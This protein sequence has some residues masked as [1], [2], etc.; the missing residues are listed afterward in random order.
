MGA[1]ASFELSQLNVIPG[2][3]T[4]TRLRVRNTGSVVDQ[5][6][7]EPIGEAAEWITVAPAELSLF[8]AAEETVVVSVDAPREPT[9]R[10]GSTP[11]A[12]RVLSR[13][14]PTGSVAEEGM[15]DV[16]AFDERRVELLPTLSSSSRQGTHELAVDNH[17]NAPIRPAF[18]ALDP[19]DQLRFEID[20]SVLSVEPGTAGFATVKVRPKDR[21]W[22]G[23]PK[24]LP[25]QI[26]AAEDG[27]DPVT[28]EGALL[29]QPRLPRWFW[30][31]VLAALLLLLLLFILWKTLLEPS[32]ESTARD[33]AEELVQEEVA[34]IDERLDAAGIPEAPGPGEEPGG[35]E[36]GGGEDTTPPTVAEVTTTTAADSGPT[37][38]SIVTATT[39]AG[40]SADL[41]PLGQPIDFRL[42]AVVAPTATGLNSFTVPAGQVLSITDIVLQNPTGATGDLRIKRSGVTLFETQLA[43][44]R[45]L[46][47]HFVSPYQFAEGAT[48]D[49]EVICTVPGPGTGECGAS[50]S[51]AG[52]QRE[53]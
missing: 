41:S 7:F 36:P 34:A 11:F 50:A 47:F 24:R 28:A 9:T 6:T 19:E 1:S 22:R 45:D 32:I 31:A 3:H 39:V 30:K 23:Q 14:D 4:E 12:I 29:Q 5:F 13:E 37:T 16:A 8:P 46:D 20:P 17:G 26:V 33:S 51:F 10:H 42:A 35:E 52:F 40:G 43:N 49:L 53:A 27:H 48:V 44:Y 21:F 18:V 38:T 15:L 25:F 2:E